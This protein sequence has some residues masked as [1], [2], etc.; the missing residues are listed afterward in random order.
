M[1]CDIHICV[2]S[3]E[4]TIGLEKKWVNAD[5]WIVNSLYLEE[6]ESEFERQEIYHGRDYG[7]FAI[8]ADVRNRDG[9]TPIAS[10]RGLPSNVSKQ[11][12]K[13]SDSWGEDGHSHS[14]FLLSELEQY[15]ENNKISFFSGFVSEEGAKAIDAGEMPSTWCQGTNNE[16]WVHR[17]WTKEGS[18]L[19]DLIEKIKEHINKRNW[20][21]VR[22]LPTRSVLF[23]GSITNQRR[24]KN[25]RDM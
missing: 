7:L 8:L 9:V 25:G 12:K 3:K 15:R 24:S 20:C 1:G 10:P 18:P 6:G 21:V 11:T 22:H 16:T 2:E 23:F 13:E 5:D 4:R 19:D 17:K 14:Y